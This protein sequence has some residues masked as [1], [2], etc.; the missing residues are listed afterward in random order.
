MVKV[1]FI[2][3]G[4]VEKILIESPDF[5]NLL[6]RLDLECI[7]P[8]INAT[9]KDNLLPHRILEHRENLKDK[10]AEII[11]IITDLDDLSCITLTKQ[12][13][14]PLENEIIIV[15]VKQIESWF[16]ADSESMSTLFK[17]K[18]FF[19]FPER[20]MIP[21]ETIR[22]ESLRIREQGF[23]K[24]AKLKFAAKY[25]RNGFSIE[26]AANHPNCPS[27]RYFINKLQ[28]LSKIHS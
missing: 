28:S 13:I 8:I 18:Y 26:N 14:K 23:G 16:L 6:K 21:Y 15:S 20:E 12:R 5:Q 25:I 19:E 3:E 11:I 2:C 9:G 7:K 10:Q 24:N 1:G 17:Q 22:R 4:D 27:A